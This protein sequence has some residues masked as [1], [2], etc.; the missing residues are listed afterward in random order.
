MIVVYVGTGT[1]YVT[2]LSTD[3]PC[4][5]MIFPT[6]HC[7]A[8]SSFFFFPFLLKIKQIVHCFRND[9]ETRFS[10]GECG[11]LSIETRRI[12]ISL[13]LLCCFLSSVIY[14]AH[15]VPFGESFTRSYA[16]KY[17]FGKRF[18][19]PGTHVDCEYLNLHEYVTTWML[20]QWK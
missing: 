9:V 3:L 1:T 6:G 16:R 20:F 14:H 5:A 10:G 19:G 13:G 17:N 15:N 8:V 18:D 4:S 2:I 7:G 11:S 12:A